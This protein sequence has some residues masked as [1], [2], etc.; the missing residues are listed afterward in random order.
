MKVKKLKCDRCKKKVLATN[1][2]GDER[3]YCPHCG[4]NLGV[5]IRRSDYGR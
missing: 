1:K 3:F 4:C 2:Y 5:H